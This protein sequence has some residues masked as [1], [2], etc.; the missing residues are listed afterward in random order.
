MLKKVLGALLLVVV[1]A[2]AGAGWYFF[3]ATSGVPA[4]PSPNEPT[5][6]RDE[7][8]TISWAGDTMMGWA[9]QK[10]INKKGADHVLSELK[11]LLEA[12]YTVINLE[13][14]V[15]KLEREDMPEKQRVWTYN[16]LPNTISAFKR[17][18]IDAFGLANNHAFDRG[19][20]GLLETLQFASDGGFD[21]F[22][23]GMSRPEA[24]G[25][26]L[27]ETPHGTVGV[28]GFSHRGPRLRQAKDGEV[29]IVYLH[30]EQV[31]RSYTAAKAAGAK[32]VVAF[33]HWGINYDVV[34]AA[35]MR[36][37]ELFAEVGYDLVVGQGPHV[38]QPVAMFGDMP[39]LYS[40][41][42]FV[43]GTQGRFQKDGATFDPYG[44]IA[45]T[46]VGPTG[47]ERIELRCILVDNLKVKYR[48]R[49]C[50][51]EERADSYRKLGPGVVVQGDAAVMSF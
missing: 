40:L 11:P 48:P 18:G 31:R 32:W 7:H 43:F 15:T 14:P 47:F 42:N 45:K 37:A 4:A 17:A 30:E 28:V 13:A 23:V 12:D 46:F 6:P 41:G 3:A 26:L 24:E 50:S 27:I 36:F 20:K 51:A 9:G 29:G 16:V 22:G 35:D 34:K 38:Q 49:P 1:L 8:F 33:P 21:V 5:A 2:G 44:L 39:V 10:L 25:P 19:D